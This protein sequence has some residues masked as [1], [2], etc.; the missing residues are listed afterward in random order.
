MIEGFNNAA[1]Q[2]DTHRMFSDTM[3]R[4]AAEEIQTNTARWYQNGV[5]DRYIW[6]KAGELGIIGAAAPAEFGGVGGPRSLDAITIYHY[7]RTGDTGW[8]VGIQQAVIHYVAH[9]GTIEQK[10]RWLPD[11]ISGAKVAALG[12]TE[13]AA[14][15]DLQGLQTTAVRDGN[16][17]RINGSKTFITNGGTA[18]V[19]CL[20]VK[21][22]PAERARGIS[23]MMVDL[24]DQPGFRRGG[25]LR[26]IGMKG[27]DTAELFFDDVHVPA[28]SLLGLEEGRGF[29]QMM[30]QL[31]WERLAIGVMALGAIDC[32]LA[33][34]LTYVRE[35]RAF[36]KR[37]IDFQ[38]SRFKLAEVKTKAEVLR[39]FITDCIGRL[40]DGKLDATTASMAKWWGTQTQCEVVDDCLQLFGGY[41]FMQDYPIGRMYAD[42][43]VQKIYGGTNEI[44]KDL[45]ARSLDS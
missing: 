29:Y 38:N 21:T 32:A 14:G 8:G 26:K 25:N 20:V 18:D 41:G 37:I 43:R 1:W 28:D 34:T 16:G 36:G 42:A 40:D 45:I 27:Q 44:M 10:R 3:A 19:V 22:N 5:V 39:S 24:R 17:Y 30:E 11:L 31:P 4:F 13:P 9:Y 33:E 23:L 35:R 15:S 12:M 7:T 2:T 6:P